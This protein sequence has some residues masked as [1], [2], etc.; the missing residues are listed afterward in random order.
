MMLSITKFFH[1]DFPQLANF[2]LHDASIPCWI[3]TWCC[4]SVHV[5]WFTYCCNSCNQF[6]L[7]MLVY[8]VNYLLPGPPH[9]GQLA[10]GMCYKV[11]WPVACCVCSN[12]FLLKMLVHVVTGWGHHTLLKWWLRA[13]E[14]FSLL[15]LLGFMVVKSSYPHNKV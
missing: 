15:G 4:W 12:Y 11:W 8:A 10:V 7:K 3:H 14:V 13:L 2:V 6:I 5:L 1:I 9:I